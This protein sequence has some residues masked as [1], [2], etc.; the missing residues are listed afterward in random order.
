MNTS[1]VQVPFSFSSKRWIWSQAMYFSPTAKAVGGGSDAR[2]AD[3]TGCALKKAFA[4][5]D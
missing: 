1:T 2:Q 3:V 4:C 5:L